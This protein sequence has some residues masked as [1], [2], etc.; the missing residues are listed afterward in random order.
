MEYVMFRS[1]LFNFIY[2]NNFALEDFEFMWNNDTLRIWNAPFDEIYY[3]E[4]GIFESL[5]VNSTG[6]DI[7]K[8]QV[9]KTTGIVQSYLMTQGSNVMYYEIKAQ[10]LVSWSVGEGDIIYYKNN[11]EKFRDIKITILGTVSYY[12]NISAMFSPMGLS[13]PSGQPELQFYSVLF[14]DMEEWDDG[15]STW[16]YEDTNAIAVSNIYWPI[17]PLQFDFG[18]P[19]IM[20]ENTVIFS[21]FH[22][23]VP[24]AKLKPNP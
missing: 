20:P 22:F 24:I 1:Y 18:P 2:P 3:S 13:I 14:A 6:T 7:V 8:S 19:L 10:T 9:D 4:N 23:P 17:S 21:T 16:V 5:V 15:S 11:E 12:A